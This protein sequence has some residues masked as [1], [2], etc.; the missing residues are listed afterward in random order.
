MF[1]TSHR[2]PPVD[3]LA[4]ARDP[5]AVTGAGV[6]AS[7]PAEPRTRPLELVD[8]RRLDGEDWVV[9]LAGGEGRRIRSF[10]TSSDGVAVPKQFCRFRDHR[11]LLRATIDRALALTSPER[12][13]V[14]VRDEHRR[15]WEDETD[16]LPAANVLSQPEDRGTA[17]AILQ[18]LVE[19]HCRDREPRLVVMPSDSDVD[20]E[21]VLLDAVR[22]ARRE[23]MAHEEEIVLLGI[24]PSHVDSEYGLIVPDARPRTASARVRAFVEKPP[25][26]TARRLTSEGA[27]WNSF[28]FACRGWALY[29][30]FEDALPQ[31]TSRYLHALARSSS[32]AEGRALA[33]LDVPVTDFGRGVLQRCTDRLRM[34]AVPPCGW[35]DLGTPARLA[36]WL[37][38]HRDAAFWSRRATP[39]DPGGDFGG[40]VQTA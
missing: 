35:T 39:R 15:W 27:M 23:A 19:I 13:I 3:S 24:T 34:L 1:V 14:L 10:T 21:D 28:I 5:H 37:Y 31:T 2:R 40:A 17:V 12:V 11:T 4:S 26:T 32:R 30:L 20:D 9:V 16:G 7:E 29:A 38:R 22:V 6:V 8:D 36:S 18:A 25:I 33:A